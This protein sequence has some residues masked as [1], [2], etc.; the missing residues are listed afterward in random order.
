[1]ALA[2]DPQPPLAVW[3]ALE[4]ATPLGHVE[5][6]SFPLD[7]SHIANQYGAG[8]YGYMWS[9]VIALDMLSPFKGR[10]ARCQVGARYRDAI[11]ARAASRRRWPR[12]PLPRPRAFQRRLLRRDHRQALETN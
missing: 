8:Y 10:H 3:K 9:E 5:G 6:T 11:L 2:T 12:A 7:F 4:N 1:M